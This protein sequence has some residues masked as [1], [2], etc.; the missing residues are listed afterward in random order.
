MRD[1]VRFGKTCVRTVMYGSTEQ[2]REHSISTVRLLPL[3]NDGSETDR[4]VHIASWHWIWTETAGNCFMT[5][6]SPWMFLATVTT[7]QLQVRNSWPVTV[8]E[9]SKACTAFVR[10]EAGIMCSNPT[11]G[12]Y[13]WCLCMCV[14]FPVFVYKKRLCDELITRPRSPTDCLRSSKL[15]WN[16]KFHG[17]R[18][19]PEVGL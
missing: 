12:I 1:S 19:R 15:K 8:A 6:T 13:V 3:T 16:W 10:S 9:R 18:P 2:V 5:R 11:E 7:V 17:G 14:R 4:N